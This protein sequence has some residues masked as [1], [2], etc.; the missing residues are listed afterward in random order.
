MYK[1]GIIYRRQDHFKKD[2]QTEILQRK[3]EILKEVDHKL[4]ETEQLI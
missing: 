1:I 2:L 3:G 4:G